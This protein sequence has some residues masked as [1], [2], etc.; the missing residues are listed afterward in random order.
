MIEPQS[1]EEIGVEPCFGEMIKII[2]GTN[3]SLDT[4]CIFI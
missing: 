4:S 2:R 3:Q 1:G